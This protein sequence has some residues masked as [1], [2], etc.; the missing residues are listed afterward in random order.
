MSSVLSLSPLDLAA[1]AL[2]PSGSRVL[3]AMLMGT[4]ASQRDK[5]GLMARLK[6]GWGA[7]AMKP[8]GS[9]FLEK[10]FGWTVRGGG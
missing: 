1:V 2:D 3:E 10:A 5:E 7:V 4:A 6:G 9:F 8:A